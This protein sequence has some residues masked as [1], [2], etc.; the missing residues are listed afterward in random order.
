MR[1]KWV[2]AGW[3]ME[4]AEMRRE[5]ERARNGESFIVEVVGGC[6]CGRMEIPERRGVEGKRCNGRG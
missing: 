6:C 1:R 4:V 5:A 3:G 2:S